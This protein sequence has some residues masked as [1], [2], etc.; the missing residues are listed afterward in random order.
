MDCAGEVLKRGKSETRPLRVRRR[1]ECRSISSDATPSA[2]GC[3]RVLGTHSGFG[4][5]RLQLP[6]AWARV[7]EIVGM[8]GVGTTPNGPR[9][10]NLFFDLGHYQENVIRRLRLNQM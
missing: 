6:R 5:R 10:A 3:G 2:T 8:M 1:G 7:R 4:A 9:S